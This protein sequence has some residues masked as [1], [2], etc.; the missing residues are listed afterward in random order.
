M[1]PTITAYTFTFYAADGRPCGSLT[2]QTPTALGEE[3]AARCAIA[4]AGRM[5]R[6]K[7]VWNLAKPRCTLAR[8][9]TQHRKAQAEA[10]SNALRELHGQKRAFRRYEASTSI[11][12]R[13]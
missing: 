11:P 9:A 1:R 3:H 5:P 12:A 13:W 7:A 2:V 10:V 6:L 8:S 4:E